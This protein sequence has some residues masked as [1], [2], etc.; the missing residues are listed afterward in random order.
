MSPSA[1]IPARRTTDRSRSKV[2]ALA[3]LFA[4]PIIAYAPIYRGGFI[5]DDDSYVT[6]NRALR[7]AD[8]LRRIWIDPSATVQY[9]PLTFTS[10]WLEYQLWQDRPMGYHVVNVLLHAAAAVLLYDLLRRL[11]VERAWPAAAIFALHPVHVESVAWITERKNVLSAV[12]YLA[13]AGAYLR[14]A[15]LMPSGDRR[16]MWY[17]ASLILFACALLSKTATCSLPAALLLVLWWRRGRIA[18]RSVIPLIPHL[19][20]G[21]ALGLVTIHVERSHVGTEQV[22]LGLSLGRRFVIAGM[23]SWFYLGKLLWPANLSFVYP[24]WNPEPLRALHFVPSVLMA[25]ALILLWRLR[26]RIGRGPAAAALFFIGTLLPA[27]GFVDAYIFQYSFVTDH[28]QY[29]ASIGPLIALTAMLH[30]FLPGRGFAVAVGAWAVVLAALTMGRSIVFS[31]AETLWRDTLEKNDSA[32]MAHQNLGVL[33]D[34]RGA[35]EEA[36]RHFR[37]AMEFRPDDYKLHVNLAVALGR[38]GRRDEALEHFDAALRLNPE[39][40]TAHYNLATT[41]AA[42]GRNDDAIRHFEAAL[43]FKPDMAAAAYNIGVI[44]ER[45]GRPGEARLQFRRALDIDP[46][47]T[48]ARAR[49]ER[50]ESKTGDS[51][52]QAAG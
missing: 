24:R 44:L 41:L 28:F 38:L 26:E 22:E 34:N 14:F 39:S 50:L 5:W 30:R 31:E 10:F 49:L 21:L 40:W 17:V 51:P 16:G 42:V 19:L 36:I 20:L 7:D 47:F 48:A 33:L 23:G 11:G 46:E 15:G 32:W 45:Q 25:A 6:Q 2:L 8:G 37:R 3:S 18:A 4:L 52:G 27:L 29:L 12:F 43:E 35:T 9:Y 13:A 1:T